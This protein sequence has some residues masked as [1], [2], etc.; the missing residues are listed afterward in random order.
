[1][2]TIAFFRRKQIPQLSLCLLVLFGAIH[3]PFRRVPWGTSV[4]SRCPHRSGHARGSGTWFICSAC[5]SSQCHSLC[6]WV[7]ERRDS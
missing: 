7:L 4:I 6:W 5:Q 1:M 3:Q 2:I